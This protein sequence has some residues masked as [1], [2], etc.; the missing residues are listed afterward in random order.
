VEIGTAHQPS[1]DPG[2]L[3]PRGCGKLRIVEGEKITFKYYNNRK[4]MENINSVHDCRKGRTP[5]N[6]P[7]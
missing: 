7:G 5:L 3:T 4:E 1:S 2:Y 6:P